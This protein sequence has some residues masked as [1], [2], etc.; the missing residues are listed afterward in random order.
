MDT[1]FRFKDNTLTIPKAED[2]RPKVIQVKT[3]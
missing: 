2:V 1:Q 3:T